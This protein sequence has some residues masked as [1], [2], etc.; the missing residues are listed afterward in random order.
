MAG[1]KYK[2]VQNSLYKFPVSPTLGDRQ[3]GKT[4]RNITKQ[5]EQRFPRPKILNR[6]ERIIENFVAT[7]NVMN[8]EILFDVLR[9][10]SNY[11]YD[12]N[13]TTH[14]RIANPVP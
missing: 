5:S 2:N 10:E 6:L 14:A 9:Q 7:E 1:Q 8:Q 4:C 11:S 12:R 3:V 13:R